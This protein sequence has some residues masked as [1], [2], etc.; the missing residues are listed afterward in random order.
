MPG[1]WDIQRRFGHQVYLRRQSLEGGSLRDRRN[2][3]FRDGLKKRL[4]FSGHQRAA[5]ADPE[6]AEA[7]QKSPDSRGD[8]FVSKRPA[9]RGY[10]DSLQREDAQI[11]V[12]D[13]VHL[14]AGVLP[15]K[16]ES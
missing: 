5:L 3:E 1:R 9:C 7:I 14:S 10:P 6:H 15:V 2:K 11:R 13:A 4:E 16:S 8:D 12:L